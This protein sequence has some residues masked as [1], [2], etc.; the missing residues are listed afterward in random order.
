MRRRLTALV[1]LT[2]LCA[3]KAPPPGPTPNGASKEIRDAIQAGDEAWSRANIAGDSAAMRNLYTADMVSMQSDT[4]DI[5]GRDAMVADLA[6]GFATR[7]D[8]VLHIET[9]IVSLEHSGDLAWEA[10]RVTLTK[11]NRDSV[12]AAPRVQRFKYITFWQRGTDGK[13]R[14]RRDL[15]VPDLIPYEQRTG[16]SAHPA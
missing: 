10:G 8:T 12:N 15:G 9:V 1:C 11:R 5:V 13:W 6:H 16:F 4:T 3:C 7:K 2:A 14:I